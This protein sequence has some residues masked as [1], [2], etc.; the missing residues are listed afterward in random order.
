MDSVFTRQS[1][2]SSFIS[3]DRDPKMT[4][5]SFEHNIPDID[6]SG[7]N[8]QLEAKWMGHKTDSKY[9]FRER[10]LSKPC[11]FIPPLLREDHRSNH[12]HRFMLH[13]ELS[14]SPPKSFAI[15]SYDGYDLTS[16]PAIV[17]PV[18]ALSCGK[19]TASTDTHI[20][21]PRGN[22]QTSGLFRI[23]ANKKSYTYIDPAYGGSA[24]FM[25]RLSEMASL[26]ADTIRQEN[27]KK[28]KKTKRLES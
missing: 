12:I 27:L 14:R 13:K 16:D 20:N 11:S 28:L 10:R 26:E 24:S 25:A 22:N 21:R 1:T 18:T 4:R 15:S 19:S 8:F 7:R 2:Y 6:V 17:F 3:R 9:D 23:G 5:L